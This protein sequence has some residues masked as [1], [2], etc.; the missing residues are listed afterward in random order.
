MRTN[1]PFHP[2]AASALPPSA[3]AVLLL[4]GS[5]LAFV[6]CAPA[7]SSGPVRSPR[8]QKW[9]DRA[10]TSYRTMDVEDAQDAVRQALRHAPKD[11]EIR[12]LAA[13]LALAKLDYEEAIRLT[14]GTRDSQALAL[15]GRAQW[16]AGHVDEAGASLERLLRD[17]EVHDP[18]AKA[19]SKLA[20][21]G[22]E[23]EPYRSHGDIVAAMEMPR[24]RGTAL[25]VPVEIDGEQGLALV[26]TGTAE[27]VIDKSQ[28]REPSWVSLRFD[29]RVEY[30]DVP[31]VTQDLSGI[32]RQLGAPIKAMLGVNFLRN[33]NATFDLQGR[34]FVVRQFVPPR[35]PQATDVALYYVR[36]GGM[37]IRSALTAD[38]APTPASLLIDSSQMFPLALDEE[39]WRKAGLDAAELTPLDGEPSIKHGVAP[40]IRLGAFDVPQVRGVLSS[41]IQTLET[42]L[43]LNIDGVIGSGLLGAFRVTL[44]DGGR[45]LWMEED[46][47][48]PPAQRDRPAPEPGEG[49]APAPS[50]APSPAPPSSSEEPTLMMPGSTE[51]EA[52]KLVPGGNAPAK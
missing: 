10:Q 50:P 1:N 12:L 5:L 24:V 8:A 46:F 43:G 49:T 42:V 22:A 14:E 28:R 33:A 38:A 13:N 16:Y 32:S 6:A 25:V 36:G 52:P 2:T 21:R 39:G 19:I 41:E 51:L 4:V 30:Q 40:M 37:M 48:P 20:N 11:A 9:F 15:R 44:G 45:T 18:W 7:K 31:A 17:P 23:R 29:G 3:V 35:P 34:Q 26:S 27:V 47:V